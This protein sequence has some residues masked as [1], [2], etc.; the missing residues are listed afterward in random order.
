VLNVLDGAVLVI[1]AVDV[2]AQTRVLLRTLQRLR[3]PTLVSSTRSTAAAP[4]PAG[5]ARD[6]GKADDGDR[7]DRIGA[8]VARAKR[9][10]SI[11]RNGRGVHPRL[12]VLA[13][14]DDA[15]LAAFVDDRTSAICHPVRRAGGAHKRVCIRCCSVQPS[16]APVSA[17]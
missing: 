11:R 14:H 13:D 5:H 17:I 1:S 6:C 12:S 9:L 8:R 3:I 7:G 2:Q 15:V 16:P 10:R 4:T